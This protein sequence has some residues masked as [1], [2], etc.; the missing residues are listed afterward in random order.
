MQSKYTSI[1]YIC[2]RSFLQ[3]FFKKCAV[4][5]KRIHLKKNTT[6]V[7]CPKEGN[8][9]SSV[10][11][12][13]R[14][15]LERLPL[16]T[17]STDR[18][19]ATLQDIEF[20]LMTRT[21]ITPLLNVETDLAGNIPSANT[22]KDSIF[23]ISTRTAAQAISSTTKSNQNILLIDCR[24]PYEYEGGHIRNAYNCHLPQQIINLLCPPGWDT[25]PVAEVIIFYCEYSSHRAPKMAQY[26]RSMDRNAHLDNYPALS[27]PHLY[28]ISK[29]YRLFYVEFPQ[30]CVPPGG[31]TPMRPKNKQNMQRK[32]SIQQEYSLRHS[33]KDKQSKSN[34]TL[35][36]DALL[37]PR[38]HI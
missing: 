30:L 32:Y 38:T 23:Y 13:L 31:Y 24:F 11:P 14:P 29:G 6:S 10:V 4:L 7:T 12:K 27:Y 26:L 9:N 18:T 25:Q 15:K 19:I 28:I 37:S 22:D 8:Y 17:I 36:I 34:A 20:A 2:I 5:G 35:S 21:K 33:E 1:L 3:N 16:E